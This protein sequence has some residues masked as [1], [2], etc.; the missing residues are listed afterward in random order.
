MANTVDSQV[1]KLG[2]QILRQVET[3]AADMF[4]DEMEFYA[5]AAVDKFYNQKAFKGGTSNV[6]KVYDRNWYLSN[7]FK[8]V[9]KYNT[10]G[11][12]VGPEHMGASYED[13]AE[14]VF[15][16]TMVQGIH[17]SVSL[18][19][20]TLSPSP[21]EDIKNEYQSKLRNKAGYVK[22]ALADVLGQYPGIKATIK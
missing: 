5:A 17:G 16:I 21:I 7:S 2:N 19:P 20:I 22:R 6:P 14:T 8:P 3:K 15:E 18:V 4:T 10:G 1:K 9:D 12:T 11:I 13:G